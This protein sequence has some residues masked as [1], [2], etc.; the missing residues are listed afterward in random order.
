MRKQ[1]NDRPDIQRTVAIL[2]QYEIYCYQIAYFL[3]SSECAAVRAV[4]NALLELGSD[5]ELYHLPD[6]ERREKAKRITVK[7]SLKV[8]REVKEEQR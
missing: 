3:L 7:H 2:K 1:N 6:S 5:S 8:F 4:S